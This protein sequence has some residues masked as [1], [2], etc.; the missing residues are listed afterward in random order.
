MTPEQR[1][2]AR[3]RCDAASEGPWWFQPADPETEGESHTVYRHKARKIVAEPW[4]WDDGE[5]IAHARQDLPA[6]LDQIDKI[7][8]LLRRY[9]AGETR[10]ME[11]DVRQFGQFQEVRDERDALLQSLKEAHDVAKMRGECNDTP[12]EHCLNVAR[13]GMKVPW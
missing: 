4:R 9:E 1:K 5:F 11:T 6:A 3:E 8:G 7:E 10:Q 2:A 13:A 12:C